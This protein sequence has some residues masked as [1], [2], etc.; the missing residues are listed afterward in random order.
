[1]KQCFLK[2]ENFCYTSNSATTACATPTLRKALHNRST[3]EHSLHTISA[4]RIAISVITARC[5]H[6]AGRR[7]TPCDS[8]KQ[9]GD[10]MSRSAFLPYMI[11]AT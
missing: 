2:G 4:D 8:S 7:P 5:V 6:I 9:P 11:R 1:M 10:L 3:L